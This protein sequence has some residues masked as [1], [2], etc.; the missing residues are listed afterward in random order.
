MRSHLSGTWV[1][2]LCFCL[3]TLT[4][5][6]WST[7]LSISAADM[8][9]SMPSLESGYSVADEA[10]RS[11]GGI[12]LYR[13]PMKRMMAALGEGGKGRGVERDTQTQRETHRERA[14]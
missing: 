2:V 5:A 11:V 7:M 1:V 6:S 10:T 8:S 12:A 3:H 4:S 13:L 14:V 9:A